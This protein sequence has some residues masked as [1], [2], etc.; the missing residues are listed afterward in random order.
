MRGTLIRDT[1]GGTIRGGGTG[2]AGEAGGGIGSLHIRHGRSRGCIWRRRARGEGRWNLTGGSRIERGVF[3]GCW[4][5]GPG[6]EVE[7]EGGGG[8]R[9]N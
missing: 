8:D 6:W 3:P 2:V 9:W 5:D 1:T 7:R 4:G